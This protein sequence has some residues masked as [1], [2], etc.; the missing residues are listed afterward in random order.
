MVATDVRFQPE[1]FDGLAIALARAPREMDRE[2][3]AFL[4]RVGKVYIK[5]AQGNLVRDDAVASRELFDSIV[6]IV[7]PMSREIVAGARHAAAIERGVMPGQAIFSPGFAKWLAIRGIPAGAE[8]AIKRAIQRRGLPARPFMAPVAQQ[9]Q[10]ILDREIRIL[11]T[12][13]IALIQ[14]GVRASR[15]VRRS[16]VV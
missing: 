5:Q 4:T 1:G 6:Q 13:I 11:Q 14:G 7:R 3:E 2:I 12:R 10:P 16:S 9:A 8:I 15:G